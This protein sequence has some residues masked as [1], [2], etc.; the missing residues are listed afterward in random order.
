M[1]PYVMVGSAQTLL[2]SDRQ[3][4]RLSTREWSPMLM[5]TA[6]VEEILRSDD[7]SVVEKRRAALA[8]A[9]LSVRE[10]VAE[11]VPNY[12]HITA[13][14]NAMA[15]E[16]AAAHRRLQ[17]DVERLETECMRVPVG[18]D[19][20]FY[21]EQIMAAF[22]DAR[23]E[24]DRVVAPIDFITGGHLSTDEVGAVRQRFQAAERKVFDLLRHVRRLAVQLRQSSSDKA[25]RNLQRHIGAV[26]ASLTRERA[27]VRHAGRPQ[28][29]RRGSG[30][31]LPPRTAPAS[32]TPAT[33]PILC[34][35]PPLRR[36]PASLSSAA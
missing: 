33:Q 29:A 10:H 9:E 1:H 36:G 17:H 23:D 8:L 12:E 13:R 6:M 21:H 16:L 4:S 22:E 18:F 3:K 20:D 24:L 30:H 5:A 34:N 2:V 7:Y 31:T 35:A 19:G 32:P 14:L 27:A 26:R 28:R 25:L 15:P 11:R